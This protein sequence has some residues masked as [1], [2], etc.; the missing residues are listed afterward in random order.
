MSTSDRGPA[1][2][3]YRHRKTGKDYFQLMLALSVE[4][5]TDGQVTDI[6]GSTAHGQ[7]I[8]ALGTNRSL[9]ETIMLV[10]VVDTVHTGDMCIIYVQIET[11]R[12]FARE[13]GDFHRTV[14]VNG[15]RG[16]RFVLVQ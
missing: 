13:Y 8:V 12:V 11:G 7:Q 6:S 1:L 9:V 4:R 16:P 14:E 2:K 10:Q 15:E 3:R 5:F